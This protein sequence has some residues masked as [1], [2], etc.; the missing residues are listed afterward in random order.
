MASQLHRK[1]ST[2]QVKSLL[3][4]MAS[5]IMRSVKEIIGFISTPYISELMED[6]TIAF[7]YMLA[8][9]FLRVSHV[10]IINATNFTRLS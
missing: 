7:S 10:S 6:L 5:G 4:R 9:C 8:F 2:E 1:F 3:G